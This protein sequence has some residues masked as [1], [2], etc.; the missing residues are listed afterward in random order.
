MGKLIYDVII[1]Q[2]SIHWGSI[3]TYNML[4]FYAFT[5]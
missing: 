1:F 2:D 4:G 5:L 3:L